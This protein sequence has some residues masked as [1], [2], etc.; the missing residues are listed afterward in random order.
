MGFFLCVRAYL[1]VCVVALLLF[2]SQTCY[3]RT[4]KASSLTGNC[5]F[6]SWW[7]WQPKPVMPVS[8]VYVTHAP[9]WKVKSRSHIWWN[10][11]GRKDII[12][13]EW[14]EFSSER[15]NLQLQSLTFF[16]TTDFPCRVTYYYC[17][18]KSLHFTSQ[19]LN[20]ECVCAAEPTRDKVPW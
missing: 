18:E 16:L 20:F 8:Q 5:I 13:T 3:C 9:K 10:S 1:R 2:T 12:S 11:F 14:R 17:E 4:F 7:P 15:N 19:C 6:T